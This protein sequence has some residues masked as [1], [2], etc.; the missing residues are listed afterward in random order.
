[1]LLIMGTRLKYAT[2][3]C[4]P[5]KEKASVRQRKPPPFEQSSVVSRE[6]V[7]GAQAGQLAGCVTAEETSREVGEQL[8]LSLWHGVSSSCVPAA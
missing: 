4:A 5:R 1:M 7:P 2:H 6:G 3:V 8:L